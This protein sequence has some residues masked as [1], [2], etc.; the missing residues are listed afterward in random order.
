VETKPALHGVLVTFR[1]PDQLE[2]TLRR[3][4]EQD[5][6]LDTLV[7]VDNDPA[8]SARAVVEQYAGTRAATSYLPAMANLG[9][10][11]GLALGMRHA[12]G[13]AADDDWLVLLDDDDPPRTA[14]D[15]R[16]LAEFGARV[17]EQ[18]SSV[19]GVGS[20]GTRFDVARA[21][22]R[23]VP[24]AELAGAVRS[25][26]I[27]GNH[28]P[29]YSVHAVRTVGVFDERLFFGFEELEYGL[30]LWAAGFSIYA[31]G[32][33]WYRDRQ[34]YQR[35]GLQTPPQ[36]TLGDLSWRRYYSLR[37]LIV[38]LR[39]QG[40]PLAAALLALRSIAKPVYN[41]HRSPGLAVRH[42]QLNVRAITDAYRGRMG[43]TVPPQ[44]KP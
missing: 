8:E 2:A 38:I 25:D 27:S 11:G 31:D 29:F 36:R 13:S 44:P 4:A 34:H 24:D 32:E 5:R 39:Q 19:G 28:L 18:D 7:V 20:S 16:A 6:P 41:L 37:N 12:L 15:L 3:L 42:L 26:C 30:R 17:R 10:A 1:R 40:H 33:L 23:R 43:M 9:P 35:V 14:H 22:A 21:Q